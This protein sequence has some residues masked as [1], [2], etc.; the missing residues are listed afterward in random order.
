MTGS[1]GFI[2]FHVCRRLLEEGWQV[3]GIDNF[4]D[5]YDP[6][7][8]K[9]RS[10]LLKKYRWFNNW[11]FDIKH[12]INVR[13]VFREVQPDCVIHLAAQAGVRRSLYYPEEYVQSNVQG[14]LS[15][16][17]AARKMETPPKVV[18][19]SSSSVY[20]GNVKM[21]F[22]EEDSVD[23]PVSYYAATKRMAELTACTYSHLYGLKTV[24]LRFFT[25]YGP[26]GRPDMAMW[27]FADSI[28]TG[29]PLS[30]FNS[31]DMQRD[32]TYIDD[33]VDGILSA[34]VKDTGRNNIFNLAS[35]RMVG[36][37]YVVELIEKNMGKQTEHKLERMQQ[38][39]VLS[40]FADI[41]KA[42]DMLDY[43]PV[44]GVE[45]GIKG[46]I[47]WYKNYAG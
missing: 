21:P 37:K 28:R 38:G 9:Q 30:L 25:V 5:S 46:F 11:S 23:R 10:E 26:W 3:E 14:T 31:G 42:Q 29:E 41:S 8:K 36:L 20:G 44:T 4:N 22:S 35:G 18:Y 43:K 1:A 16:M 12:E 6:K 40:T 19:A 7:I 24:G 17:E 39:D 2:G 27:L 33:I 15:V 32:F 47:D 13:Q 34:V 45:K